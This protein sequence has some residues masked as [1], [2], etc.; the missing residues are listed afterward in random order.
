M[1]FRFA[2]AWM[3]LPA[4]FAAEP[5][6]SPEDASLLLERSRSANARYVESLPDFMC[7]QVVRRFV[8]L[9]RPKGWRPLDTLTVKL[10]Y[11]EHKEDRRLLLINGEPADRPEELAGGLVN[12][13]E[14]GGMLQTIFDPA[15]ETRFQWES[16][17]IMQGRP[18]AVY[19]YEVDRAHSWYMLRQGEYTISREVVVAYH[20]Q[21]AID[22]E[23]GEVLRLVYQASD[24]PKD[25]PILYASVTVD[26]E[27]ADAG[28]KRYLLPA[29]SE[30]ET[31]I[32][33]LRTRNQGEFR[34][35]QK[36]TADSSIQFGSE[37]Q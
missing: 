29:R 3:C 11:S 8:E 12:I 4:V 25:F 26:Y 20:G 21:V 13:G 6:P 23:T 1:R 16:W 10:S 30:T 5:G 28:G 27:Y 33:G 35:Y 2:I 36:F 17:Q 32:E 18:V 9:T 31:G 34:D 19:S 15:T 22:K 7:T 14:F 37:K 24:I